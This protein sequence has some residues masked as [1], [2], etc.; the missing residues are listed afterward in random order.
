[1]IVA[2]RDVLCQQAFKIHYLRLTAEAAQISTLCGLV[3][4]PTPSK[5][6]A[7]RPELTVQAVSALSTT[8]HCE[9]GCRGAI[10]G[11]ETD[12]LGVDGLDDDS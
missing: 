12:H 3:S 9:G 8:S 10:R 5:V 4:V 1:M 7:T 6:G 2:G 11:V